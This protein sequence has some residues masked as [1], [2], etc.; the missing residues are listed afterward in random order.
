[1][2]PPTPVPDDDM[3]KDVLR[4]GE[5]KP[6]GEKGEEEPLERARSRSP[7][8]RPE[9][10]KAPA[11]KPLPLPARV[12]RPWDDVAEVMNKGFTE[13][14]LGGHGDCGFRVVAAGLQFA[15]DHT[16][17]I[18][19][20]ASKKLGAKIRG[21][22]VSYCRCHQDEFV[23]FFC[24]NGDS[25]DADLKAQASFQEWLQAMNQPTTWVDGL[26]LKALSAQTG[27]ILIIWIWTNDHWVRTTL[28]P[29]FTN[30][31]AR[32]PKGTKPICLLLRKQQYTW[33]KQPID[34]NIPDGWLKE[35]VFPDFRELQG[36]G[37]RTPAAGPPALSDQS[38]QGT[39]KST[40]VSVLGTPSASHRSCCSVGKCRVAWF[41]VAIVPPPLFTRCLRQVVVL[42]RSSMTAQANRSG[43]CVVRFKN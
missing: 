39:R 16:N 3:T 26:C 32:E 4:E 5:E 22:A 11:P 31:W 23:N 38:S 17:P 24:D 2:T 40:K 33:L 37:K 20:E 42:L 29:S 19:P 18:S 34:E 28:A 1:M 13:V 27:A 35:S 30:G 21:Q 14:D 36:S 10:N 6:E 9:E 43:C 7:V 12:P 25:E 8:R 41:P 15:K